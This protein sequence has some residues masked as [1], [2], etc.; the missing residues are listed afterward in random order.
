M[1]KPDE[2][3]I[4]NLLLQAA[5]LENGEYKVQLLE[6]AV[7]LADVKG[8][9]SSQIDA[10]LDLMQAAIFGG[11]DEKSFVAYS[12]LLSHYDREPE[13]FSHHEIMWRYKWVILTIYNFPQISLAQIT[14]MFGDMQRRYITDNLSLR[15]LYQNLSR[16]YRSMGKCAEADEYFNKWENSRRDLFADCTTCEL[17]YRADYMVYQGRDEDA[18]IALEPILSGRLRCAEVPHKTY[19]EVLLPLIRLKRYEEAA[20]YQEKGYRLIKKNKD[21]LSNIGEHIVYLTLAGKFVKALN[22]L[23]RH[24]VWSLTMKNS[25]ILFQFYRAVWFMLSELAETGRDKVHLRLPSDFAA[26]NA[27]NEY[28]TKELAAYFEKQLRDIAAAFDRRNGN[29]H[30]QEKIE[31]TAELKEFSFASKAE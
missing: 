17:N 27:D 20:Q 25:A 26:Y 22:M 6:E 3:E 11:A 28:K 31:Q 12:W 4:Y 18:I 23:E 14:A 21:F 5:H 16:L 2:N 10:R 13:L 29:E 1:T 15:P 9:L 30:H 24:L 7:Q 8:T 19:S